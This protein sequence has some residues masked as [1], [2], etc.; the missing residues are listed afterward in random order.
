MFKGYGHMQALT[1][2]FIALSAGLV[3]SHHF[4][5]FRMHSS[6]MEFL[7]AYKSPLLSSSIVV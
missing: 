4:Q 2:E 5:S 6:K 3:C 7:L 1:D